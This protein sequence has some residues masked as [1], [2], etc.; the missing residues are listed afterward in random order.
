MSDIMLVIALIAF[1]LYGF[2]QAAKNI[3]RAILKTWKEIRND[4]KERSEE[5]AC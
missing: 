5:N 4:S 1:A 3:S 2:V